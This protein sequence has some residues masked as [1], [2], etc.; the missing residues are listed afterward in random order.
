MKQKYELADVVRKFGK[1]LLKQKKLSPRQIKALYNIIRCRTAS[2]G[3]HEETCDY[4]GV[5]SYSYNSCGDRHCPKCQMA[6]QISWVDKLIDRTMPTKHYHIVFTVPHCLNNIALWNDRIYYEVLFKAVWQTLYSF[7]YT[8]YGVETGAV[9]VLHTWGQ[10]LSL[11]PHVHCIVPSAGYSLNGRWK[12]IGKAGKYLY[13][14]D[15]LSEAFKG[16]F[17]YS[18]KRKLKSMNSILGFNSII[19]KAYSKRWVVYCEPALAKA[20][21]VVKYLGQYTHRVAIS[22]PNILNIS[23]THVKFI[24]KDYRDNAKKRPVR[25]TGVEFLHRFCQHVL[26]ERFVKIRYYGIYNSTTKRN[27]KLKFKEVTIEIIKKNKTTIK[28]T[29]QQCIKRILGYDINQCKVCKKG[30]LIR[31]RQLPKIRAP[32]VHLPTLLLNQLS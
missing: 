4:C 15:Q 8:H 13:P 25:L 20:H 18:L 30:T 21:H 31:I 1:E 29:A 16:R 3:G 23:D 22:N 10:N 17:L 2:L 27:M 6:K 19:E 11:H 7:G 9:A 14:I 5:I 26:P 28:E 24:T 32:S 12:N